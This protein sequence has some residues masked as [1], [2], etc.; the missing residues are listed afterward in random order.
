MTDKTKEDIKPLQQQIKELEKFYNEY[1]QAH[2]Q[3]HRR[4]AAVVRHSN[5]AIM[6]QDMDGRITAWNRG[7]EEMYGYA[8]EEALEMNIECITPADKVAE[9]KEFARRLITGEA[10]HSF[11][12]QRVTKDGRILD[13]WLS[14]TKLME[15]PT[16]SIVSTGR[17]VAKPIGLALMERNITER[18]LAEQALR[19]SE[20]RFRTIFEEAPLGIALI[21][22]LTGH[23]YEV[24]RRFAEIAGR[25]RAI[26][27]T[28]DWMSITHPDDV[29]KDLDHMALM[30]AGKI[31]GFNMDKRYLLP[32]GAFVWI[33]MTIAPV[34]V[35]DKSHPQHFCMI[36]DIT[37]RQRT[38]EAL[39]ISEINNRTLVNNI[40]QKIFMKDRNSVYISC[41]ANYAW[42]L[43]IKPEEIFGKTDHEF[44]P[45]ELAEQYRAD[46]KRVMASGKTEDIEEKYI[47][48]GQE[49]FIHT[50]KTPVRDKQGHVIGI[51]GIIR[52]ITDQKQLEAADRKQIQELEIFYK[53]SIGRE[54]RIIELKKEI[55]MLKKELGR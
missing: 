2:K 3:D 33:N 8:E 22:S 12:T 13:V 41:N 34:S 48:D 44:H 51:L 20:E 17:D 10:V 32:D 25:T 47:Q 28:I 30:N 27:A 26:M 50:V 55:E 15:D 5:D 45:K 4:L 31:T 39:R 14:M 7:A 36:K 29:Q 54:Q 18:K 37:E 46:D 23:F 42:D 49:K 40:P 38:E 11:E 6:I 24:N 35:E 53:A 1:K 52:D 19:K 21:D 43:K 9:Q 16:D